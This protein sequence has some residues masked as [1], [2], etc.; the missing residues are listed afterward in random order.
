MF[1]VGAARIP[2]PPASCCPWETVRPKTA[3]EEQQKGRGYI[4]PCPS[5]A[6]T[7]ASASLRLSD[8]NAL[9]AI[10][11]LADAFVRLDAGHREKYPHPFCR[12]S[13]AVLGH[14]VSQGQQLAG[15][16]GIRAAS[17]RV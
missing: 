4:F 16:W 3:G 2:H 1:L 12:S 9:S 8:R 10:R 17:Q 7:Y 15:G 11:R 5:Q 13:P 6:R 14:T